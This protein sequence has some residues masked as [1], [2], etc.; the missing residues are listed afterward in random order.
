MA[1]EL[2]TIGYS[3]FPD[4]NSFIQA[5]KDHGVQ[6]LIDV[7]SSPYSAYYT[8]YDKEQLQDKLK[9][10]GIYY[11]NYARQFGA[12]Q[13]NRAF[14]RD[15]RLD[16]C[17][18]AKSQQFLDGVRSVEESS[19]VIVFMC[20]EKHPSECHRAILVARAFH[21]RGYQVTHI[22]PCGEAL[23][24]D[25]IEAE[26]VNTYFPDRAQESLFEEYNKTEEECIA[27]AYKLRNDQIGF[28]LEDLN[29]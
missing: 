10:N 19:A 18:F 27:E 5:L 14:Y 12:R 29:N 24:Q 21:D 8:E 20:A 7:R 3:G 28:K 16:F 15:G 9:Q 13:E 6:I 26:L 11:C 2:F 25:D 22:I 23:T 1:K 17:V 4:F